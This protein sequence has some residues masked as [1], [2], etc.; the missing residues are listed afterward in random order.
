EPGLAEQIT[1]THQNPEFLPGFLLHPQLRATSSLP[2]AAEQADVIVMAV[3]T[4]RARLCDRL[5]AGPEARRGRPHRPGDQRRG[6]RRALRTG[7]LP[8]AASQ[9]ART[10]GRARLT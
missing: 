3:P 8:W 7:C 5:L 9:Q 1:A 4:Q 6:E 10:T 2:S